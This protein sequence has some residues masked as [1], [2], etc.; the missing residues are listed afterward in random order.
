MSFTYGIEI[1]GAFVLPS[2]GMRW[3]TGGTDGSVNASC[4]HQN[5]SECRST[6]LRS[7][8]EVRR[9]IE[10][11]SPCLFATNLS[12]GTHIHVGGL[13]PEQYTILFLNK[14]LFK[15]FKTEYMHFLESMPREMYE[16]YSH[17]LDNDYCSFGLSDLKV[18]DQM[19]C[20]SNYHSIPHNSSARYKAVNFAYFAHKTVEFRAFPYVEV[21]LSFQEIKLWIDLATTSIKK[22]LRLPVDASFEE[23]IE[24]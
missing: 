16:K 2:R 19:F 11:L 10:E 9:A 21:P 5:A 24:L 15:V 7:M 18:V 20:K 4:E 13:S 6:V 22:A 23:V 1:E 12:C 3:W 17:R 8:E 14:N